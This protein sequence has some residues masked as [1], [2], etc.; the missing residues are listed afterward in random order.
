MTDPRPIADIAAEIRAN[1]RKL[2]YTGQGRSDSLCIPDC[3]DCGGSGFIP[4]VSTE[5]VLGTKQEVT[6]TAFCPRRVEKTRMGG[7][8][9]VGAEFDLTWESL[10]AGINLP[11]A[12]NT[13][14]AAMARGTGWVFLHG[15]YGTAKT[16]ILKIALAE[17][18]R[19]GG[20]GAYTSMSEILD[21]LRAAF[22]AKNPSAESEARLERWQS[23]PLL[24]I[25]E[26]D[27]VKDTE[28]AAE[29]RFRLMDDRY[30][31]AIRGE[32]SVTLMASNATPDALEGY[33]ADRIRD[34]RF[35]V[36]ELAGDSMRPGMDWHK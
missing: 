9:L 35:A 29:R 6:R 24:V 5:D 4:V 30:T 8:G 10:S 2:A 13:V 32:P 20:T 11:V 31:R 19:R 1:A 26:F 21:N 23:I 36:V 7:S 12:V 33:L 27:R 16:L 34:G 28:Y 3:P 17:W 15:G 14:K 18:L 22:D 25:D